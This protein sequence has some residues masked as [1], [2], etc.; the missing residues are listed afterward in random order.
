MLEQITT[1]DNLEENLANIKYFGIFKKLNKMN[2][3]LKFIQKY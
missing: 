1:L 3:L 2:F